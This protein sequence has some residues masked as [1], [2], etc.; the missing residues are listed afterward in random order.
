MYIVN[1]HAL[2]VALK[3]IKENNPFLKGFYFGTEFEITDQQ[4]QYPLLF[5][6]TDML[7]STA[8]K[9]G[10]LIFDKYRFAFLIIDRICESADPTSLNIDV[11][12]IQI[13]KAVASCQI[14][15]N[16]LLNNLALW[17]DYIGGSL[18]N[19][20]FTPFTNLDGKYDD[21]TYGGRFEIDLDLP[22]AIDYCEIPVI[23]DFNFNCDVL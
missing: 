17:A 6:E 18:N 20:S 7:I 14:A 1:Y 5:V 22:A 11:P 23:T 16:E 3:Q 4:M 13:I 21:R 9:T 19:Y 12:K 8:Y 2:F 15:G 10:E